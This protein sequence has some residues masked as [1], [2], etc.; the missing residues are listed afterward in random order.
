M[1]ATSAKPGKIASEHPKGLRIVGPYEWFDAHRHMDCI[2]VSHEFCVWQEGQIAVSPFK[3]CRFH[4]N[5]DDAW[6]IA[7]AASH[8][9][10]EHELPK[11]WCFVI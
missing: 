1:G 11:N 3:D 7:H 9:D 6:G 5:W 4:E 8:G 2:V 10:F